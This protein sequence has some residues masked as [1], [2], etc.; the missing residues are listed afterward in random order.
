MVLTRNE[1]RY[2]DICSDVCGFVNVFQPGWIWI[3]VDPLRVLPVAEKML[4]LLLCMFF[5][6]CQ[7]LLLLQTREIC[8]FSSLRVC[9]WYECVFARHDCMYVSVGVCVSSMFK[10][11][12]LLF[13]LNCMQF[14]M[15]I[16]PPLPIPLSQFSQP[17]TDTKFPFPTKLGTI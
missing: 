7:L 11:H 14:N 6:I 10:A 1:N 9:A 15:T 16:P 17:V 8:E 12:L 2:F 13:G 5:I 3:Y 4:L